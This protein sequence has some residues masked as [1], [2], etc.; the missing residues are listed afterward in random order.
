MEEQQDIIQRIKETKCFSCEQITYHLTQ[1]DQSE[2]Y[3]N[4]LNEIQ[5]V[6]SGGLDQKESDFNN[7]NS[8]LQHYKIIDND[9]NLLFKGKVAI[10]V[11][12]ADNILLTE[13]FF[14]GLISEL[15]DVELFSIL[16]LF[17]T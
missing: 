12:S 1:H 11:S 16:T 4:Q 7:R 2:T 17:N 10:N 15:S 14:S 13:F 5:K 9:L 6:L 3:K 8:I